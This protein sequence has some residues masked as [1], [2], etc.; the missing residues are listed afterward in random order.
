MGTVNQKLTSL[1]VNPLSVKNV[2]EVNDNPLT[3]NYAKQN[4]FSIAPINSKVAKTI[5]GCSWVI[6]AKYL[7][8]QL[9]YAVIS[10]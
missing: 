10:K 9:Q 8:K 6:L 4:Q 5:M 7:H 2:T 1:T 3:L